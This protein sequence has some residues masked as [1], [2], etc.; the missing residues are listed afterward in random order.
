M[1]LFFCLRIACFP[2][3]YQMILT[4]RCLVDSLDLSVTQRTLWLS[5]AN[6]NLTAAAFSFSGTKARLRRQIEITGEQSADL[7]PPLVPLASHL[8]ESQ[9]NLALSE[10]RTNR[11]MVPMVEPKEGKRVTVVKTNLFLI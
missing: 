4:K 11:Q 2:I 6:W 8:G 9:T 10:E 1:A 3:L 5:G 7:D